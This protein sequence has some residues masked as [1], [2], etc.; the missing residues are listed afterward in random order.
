M[1]EFS[2]ENSFVGED[3]ESEC[4]DSAAPSDRV[5]QPS[6][7]ISLLLEHESSERDDISEFKQ[8]SLSDDV[9]SELSD[10]IQQNTDDKSAYV[11]DY[12]KV[13][14]SNINYRVCQLRISVVSGAC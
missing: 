9:E 8:L 13:F 10:V 11:T 14:V 2:T 1:A 5:V 6:N 12:K 3:W 7:N 4:Y